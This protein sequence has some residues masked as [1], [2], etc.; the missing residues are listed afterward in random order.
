MLI[1]I[2]Y[3]R[4][5]CMKNKSHHCNI[6]CIHQIY[7]NSYC[8]KHSKN[9]FKTVY[10]YNLVIIQAY[11]RG[12]L[13][14]RLI[15]ELYGPVYKNPVLAH[16]NIDPISLENIWEMKEDIKINICEIPRYLIFSYK[17]KTNHIQVYNILSLLKLNQ[18]DKKDPIT[19]DVIDNNIYDT[20]TKRLEYMKQHDL[21]TD[22]LITNEK[23]S[24]NQEIKNIITEITSYLTQ[25]NIFIDNKDLIDISHY[26]LYQ[27]YN[28]CR[29]ILYHN[30]NI[31]IY[32]KLKRTYFPLDIKNEFKNKDKSE[33]QYNVFTEIKNLLFDP[34]I[35]N[36]KNNITFIILAALMYVSPNIHNRYSGTMQF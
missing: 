7:E 33:L 11:M 29:S 36:Y 4:C 5:I 23:L 19:R 20:L 34:N 21:W 12:Y 22:L 26:K 28:E 16:N 14:R 2:N 1:N 6:Q 32:Q 17:N 18:Y 3:T 31:Y 9:Q 24:K 8:K 35:Q 15:Y 27:L 30:D 10:D 13:T 25:N